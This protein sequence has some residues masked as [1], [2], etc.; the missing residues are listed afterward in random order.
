MTATQQHQRSRLLPA[1]TMPANIFR[2]EQKTMLS[3][4]RG[5][6]M[7]GD[8]KFNVNPSREIFECGTQY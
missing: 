3:L 1:K 7:A 5:S 6:R 2:V 8:L 4:L